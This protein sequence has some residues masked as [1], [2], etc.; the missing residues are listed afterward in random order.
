MINSS[1]CFY[2]YYLSG[3]AICDERGTSEIERRTSR[4]GEVECPARHCIINIIIVIVII[5][6]IFIIIIIITA[7][8][9]VPKTAP[10][11]LTKHYLFS[12]LPT[13]V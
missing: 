3:G 9:P 7:V 6:I 13:N 10:V 11:S 12:V 1:I 4:R 5:I 8:Q 2:L